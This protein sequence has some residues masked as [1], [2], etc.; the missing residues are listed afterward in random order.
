MPSIRLV[1]AAAT[2]V[3]VFTTEK[4]LA[5]TDTFDACEPTRLDEF[6]LRCENEGVG[7][8][9]CRSLSELNDQK[10]FCNE[11]LGQVPYEVRQRVLPVVLRAD[12]DCEAYVRF[13]DRCEPIPRFIESPLP[14]PFPDAS[15]PPVS[16]SPPPP[17][18]IISPAL[19][20]PTIE[21]TCDV[22]GIVSII[23][24]GCSSIVDGGASSRVTSACCDALVQLNG[25]DCFCKSDPRIQA[26]LREFPANF[27]AMFKA[28]PSVCG[29]TIRGGW[30]C[31]PFVDRTPPP[32]PPPPPPARAIQRAP[33]PPFF[34]RTYGLGRDVEAIT[35][36]VQN[37]VCSISA[38]A[39]ILDAG[40]D[41]LPSLDA[42][43]NLARRC[44]ELISL[45]NGALCF[46]ASNLLSII[47]SSR[48][49][50]YPMFAA[51]PY[52]CRPGFQTFAYQS[53][54]FVDAP[55]PLSPPPPPPPIS[56]AEPEWSW[57]WGS[58]WPFSPSPN[59]SSPPLWPEKPRINPALIDDAAR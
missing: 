31:L 12:R 41:R 46:C 36:D 28:S 49:V 23:Q 52:K 40:C 7:S 20:S 55:E 33:L 13:G 24:A 34:G 56:R 51:T 6:A 37:R 57:S 9:C 17:P 19:V 54:S 16:P 38:Y 26:L 45:M 1:S 43:T 15:P 25:E 42:N 4:A 22:D 47:E 10:C 44:C 39:S 53:C 48:G 5:Q 11:K 29:A 32:P 58:W 8:E 35:R 14:P 50:S 21:A 59:P 18:S 3:A 2:L 30:Q 27:A